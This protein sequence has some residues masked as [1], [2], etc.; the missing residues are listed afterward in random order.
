M[1]P[2]DIRIDA[3]PHEERRANEP[4]VETV[5]F[6]GGFVDYF[7]AVDGRATSSYARSRTPPSPRSKRD[8]VVSHF[9]RRTVSS[10]A[11]ES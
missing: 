11:E 7:I 9:R 1:R 3:R 2:T 8:R 4:S 6:A 10:N 5:A